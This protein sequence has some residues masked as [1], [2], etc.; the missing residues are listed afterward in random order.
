MYVTI[1]TINIQ[2]VS[3]RPFLALSCAQRSLVFNLER[4]LHACVW[5]PLIFCAH[6][7][8]TYRAYPNFVNSMMGMDSHLNWS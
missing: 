1:S 5:F 4:T 3:V 8:H 2:G 6:R 7:A